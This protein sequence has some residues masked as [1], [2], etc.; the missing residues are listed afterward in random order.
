MN[1]RAILTRLAWLAA[2]AMVVETGTIWVCSSWFWTPIQRH[3]LPA[4]IWCSLP[5]I[6][7]RVFKAV[8]WARLSS[9]MLIG[10]A[11]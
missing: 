9:E 7:K 3:Y 11:A 2:L 5:V 8:L 1:W 6:S 10:S 4:Y